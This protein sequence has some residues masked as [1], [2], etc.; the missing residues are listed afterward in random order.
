MFGW[1]IRGRW[2]GR[3]A[4]AEEDFTLVTVGRDPD[5]I[6]GRALAHLVDRCLQATSGHGKISV[7]LTTEPEALPR[8]HA[9]FLRS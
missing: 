4:T 9:P 5:E 1:R 6:E 3:G 2:T 7:E 8:L